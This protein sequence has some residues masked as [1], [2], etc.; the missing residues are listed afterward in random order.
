MKRRSVLAITA[1]TVLFTG[2]GMNRAGWFEGKHSPRHAR[3][4]SRAQASALSD[5]A[6]R[7]MHYQPLHWRAMLLQH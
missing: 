5:A 6:L 2:L 4:Q 3:H 7:H 1:L